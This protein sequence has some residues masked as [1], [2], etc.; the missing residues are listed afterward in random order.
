MD[1][2]PRTFV[3][4]LSQTLTAERYR[5]IIHQFFEEF[6]D[7]EIVDRHF[8][9][10]DATTYTTHETLNLMQ[11]VFDERVISFKLQAALPDWPDC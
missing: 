2:A 8:Q 5:D 9:Q 3:C 6:H 7:D 4:R 1:D 10:D 11:E